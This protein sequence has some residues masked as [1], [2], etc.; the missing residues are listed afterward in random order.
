MVWYFALTL[1][2]F[3][4]LA[5]AQ[6]RAVSEVES[7]SF[8][9]G[10]VREPNPVVREFWLRMEEAERAGLEFNKSV[11]EEGFVG[12]LWRRI[13]RKEKV[14]ISVENIIHSGFQSPWQKNGVQTVGVN[15]ESGRILLKRRAG[16]AWGSRHTFRE[17]AFQ[18]N[19]MEMLEFLGPELAE[20]FGLRVVDA[21]TVD[22]TDFLNQDLLNDKLE[23]L[24][25]TTQRY[26]PD[27]LITTK[28]SSPKGFLTAYKNGQV[29]LSAD[30]EVLVHDLTYHFVQFFLGEKY[31]QLFATFAS[32]ALLVSEL[33]WE[34]GFFEKTEEAKGRYLLSPF[35]P[36]SRLFFKTPFPST[37][38]LEGIALLFDGLSGNLNVLARPKSQNESPKKFFRELALNLRAHAN[39]PFL[40]DPAFYDSEYSARLIVLRHLYLSHPRRIELTGASLKE[41]S[42]QQISQHLWS[43]EYLVDEALEDVITN[44]DQARKAVRSMGGGPTAI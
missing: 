31:W 39:F 40:L 35:L 7:C 34:I 26:F 5:G 24:R 4:S 42:P 13:R 17:N 43:V 8:A 23:R 6:E 11:E 33:A 18:G 1:N 22:V 32:N 10:V 20:F 28:D 3:L 29:T 25:R 16:M 44:L 2:V 41:I 30:P 14:E 12:G 15:R 37:R 38:D 9:L 36:S 19:I 21:R 27:V